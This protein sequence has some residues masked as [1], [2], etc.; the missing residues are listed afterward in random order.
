MHIVGAL[1]SAS[2]VSFPLIEQQK[3][4][5]ICPLGSP[6]L[7]ATVLACCARKGIAP[8][9]QEFPMSRGNV[10]PAE[11]EIGTWRYRLALGN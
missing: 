7:V 1:P 8:V 3:S 11:L 9:A 10:A 2:T 4:I 5:T 6:G